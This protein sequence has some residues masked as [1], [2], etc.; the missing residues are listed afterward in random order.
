MHAA[1]F[2]LDKSNFM[3]GYSILSLHVWLAV[4]RLRGQGPDAKF[5]MQQ[6]YD[7]FQADVERR[8]YR[9]GIEVRSTHHLLPL[10]GLQRNSR[11]HQH[12]TSIDSIILTNAVLLGCQWFSRADYARPA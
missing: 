4:S 1:A 7:T 11:Q 9:A 5:V 2:G 10:A 8:V 12:R 3:S 6:M